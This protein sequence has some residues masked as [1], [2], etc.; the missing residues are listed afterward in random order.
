MKRCDRFGAFF[1]AELF[2]QAA[3]VAGTFFMGSIS[4]SVAHASVVRTQTETEAVALG[5]GDRF[6]LTADWTD[7]VRLSVDSDAIRASKRSTTASQL[8][9]TTSRRR[10]QPGHRRGN[11]G[12]ERYC[13]RR[14]WRLPA[15]QVRTSGKL[16]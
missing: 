11:T 9:M 14:M 3:L 13:D 5:D 16:L 8:P 2:L 15:L 6:V 4:A 10:K 7:T 12:R 1:A